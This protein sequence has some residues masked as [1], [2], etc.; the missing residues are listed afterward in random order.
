MQFIFA[1]SFSVKDRAVGKL[2]DAM[3]SV[4]DKLLDEAIMQTTGMTAQQVADAHAAL[5]DLQNARDRIEQLM[6]ADGN[7]GNWAKE[8]VDTGT[9]WLIDWIS[10]KVAPNCSM[11]DAAVKGRLQV[12]YLCQGRHLH[13]DQVHVGRQNRAVLQT[14]AISNG[15]RARVRT[16]LGEFRV[17]YRPVLP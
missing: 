16:D 7:L 5:N 3:T 8:G 1:G 6:N 13:G 17:A 10:S 2:T 12:E 4:R 14:T 9:D 11:Y 15:H